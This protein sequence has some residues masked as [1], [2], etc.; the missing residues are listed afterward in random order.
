MRVELRKDSQRHKTMTRFACA[1]WTALLLIACSSSH[2]VSTPSPSTAGRAHV[3]PTS[4]A[5]TTCHASSV[6]GTPIEGT[7]QVV[8]GPPPGTPVSGTVF[9]VDSRGHKCTFE[10]ARDGMFRTRLLPGSYVITGRSPSFG[11]GNRV[12]RAGP[13]V[14]LTYRDPTSHGPPSLVRVICDLS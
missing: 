6:G 9:V 2:H 11:S 12:C 7:L 14:T 5:P 4:T 3:S 13:Q 10:V 1:L 8:A